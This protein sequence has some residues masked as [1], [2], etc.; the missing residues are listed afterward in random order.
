M[1]DERLKRARATLPVGYQFRDAGPFGCFSGNDWYM[2]ADPEFVRGLQWQ[3]A[4]LPKHI[5]DEI[6]H[7]T[8]N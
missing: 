5:E 7:S 1:P 6:T 2:D 4:K 3:M 8:R